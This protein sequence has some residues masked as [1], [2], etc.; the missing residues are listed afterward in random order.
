MSYRDILPPSRANPNGVRLTQTLDIPSTLDLLALGWIIGPTRLSAVGS[1]GNVNIWD[2]ANGSVVQ[3]ISGLCNRIKHAAWSRDGN[4]LAV[5]TDM[6]CM[7]I[8]DI[9][10]NKPLATLAAIGSDVRC[11]AWGPQNKWIACG[12][13]EGVIQV[14]DLR[15]QRICRAFSAHQAPVTALGWSPDGAT[16]M[17]GSASGAV[18]FWHAPHMVMVPEM[19]VYTPKG[20]SESVRHIAWSPS[21]KVVASASDDGTIGVWHPNSGQFLLEGHTAPVRSVS[22]SP[23]GRLLAS[24]APENA[25]RLW[26]T[27]QWE[28][29]AVLDEPDS[30]PRVQSLAFHPSDPILAVVDDRSAAVKLWLLDQNSLAKAAAVQRRALHLTAKIVIVGDAGVGKTAL[31]WRLV[32]G[33]FKEQASTHGQQFWVFQA[34]S[35]TRGDGAECEAVLWDLAGQP[36]YRLVHSLFLDDADLA[37]VLFDASDQRDPLHGAEFWLE[38]LGARKQAATEYESRGCPVILVAARIDRG[39]PMLTAADIGQYCNARNIQGGFVATSA[40]TGEGIHELVDRMKVHVPWVGKRATVTTTTFKAIKDYVLDL[41]AA[42]LHSDV[43]CSLAELQARLRVAA[44][45]WRF[46]RQDV[47]TAVR[48]LEHYGYIKRLRTTTGDERILLSPDLLNNLASSVVLEARR[49][50]RGLGSIAEHQLLGGDMTFRELDGLPAQQRDLLLDAVVL[51]FIRNHVCFRETDPLNNDAYL[52]FPELINLKKPIVLSAEPTIDGPS[53]TISGA[54]QNVFASLV[55]LLGYTRTFTRTD[56]WKNNARY[57]VADGLVC[58]FRLEAEREGELDIVVYFGR[59]VGAPIRNLFQSLLESFLAR[60]NLNVVRIETVVCSRCGRTL[61]RGVVRAQ[62]AQRFA[63]CN[64][65]GCRLVLAEPEEPIQ[66]IR[67]PRE[68]M[69]VV[70]QRR[71]ADE[72][73][74]FEASIFELQGYL[75]AVF[76]G[77]PKC[78]ISYAWGERDLERWVERQLAADLQKAGVQVILDQWQNAVVGESIPRFIGQIKECDRVI[79]VGTPSYL[80]KYKNEDPAGARIV[81]AEFDIIADRLLGTENE[82]RSVLPVLREGTSD[83]SFPPHLLGRACADCRD[84]ATY[85]YRVFDLVLS[86]YGADANDQRVRDLRG[87]LRGDISAGPFR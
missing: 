29:V 18:R 86:I 42:S 44:P 4:L 63:F 82:K 57:E 2:A 21:G 45:T 24:N 39:P 71:V 35:T 81:A 25:F 59:L 3:N 46:S 47:E 60:R 30:N 78:F 5:A 34:L 6:A 64:A 37:L 32:H 61:D 55:V 87:A 14:W 52:V 36:D 23:D 83:D 50:A 9:D 67:R 75:E 54:V 10:E 70:E 22:F 69:E 20:H 8:W 85:F 28:T 38:Q 19:H 51:L 11:I 62:L 48:H 79:V 15:R 73:T 53:Y 65:C 49:N 41:K 16:L 58:G 31:A 33:D 80:R 7:E 74:L 84:D 12:F 66:L 56:Q 17:S 77:R 26:R 72:R 43:M 27:D 1:E 13:G 68:Q 40:R 76:G